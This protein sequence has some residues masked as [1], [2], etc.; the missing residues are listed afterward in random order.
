MEFKPLHKV[1][2]FKKEC[3]E[4]LNEEWKRSLTARLHSLEK[5][6]DSF[7]VCLVLLERTDNGEQSVVGHSML[8][9]VHGQDLPSCLVESVVVPKSRRGKGY[10]RIVMEKTEEFAASKGYKVMYLTTHDK[11]KFYE[12]LGYTYCSPIVTFNADIIPEHLANKLIGSLRS[13]AQGTDTTQHGSSLPEMVH[14]SSDV[15][16]NCKSSDQDN[17]IKTS[18]RNCDTTKSDRCLL[19]T[20]TTTVTNCKPIPQTAPVEIPPTEMN[21]PPPPPPPSAPPP[22]PP[23]PVV[24]PIVTKPSADGSGKITRW[25]P[26][27]VSWMKKTIV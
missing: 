26:G 15:G 21:L 12:H 5:S 9:V 11:Q 2:D 18:K 23:P 20:S 13:P 7:P 24:A 17:V 22:P 8:S 25:D 4:V 6:R 3:A 16:H 14:T 19:S 27:L 1:P 10:G